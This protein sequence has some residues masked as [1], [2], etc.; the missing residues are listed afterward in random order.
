MNM[1]NGIIINGVEYVLTPYELDD[2]MK[3]DKCAI[4]EMCYNYTCETTF[5][6]GQIINCYF[7]E[8]Q[9]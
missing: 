4:R 5:R 6:Y 8:Y 9:Y 7:E 3:C 2:G 1:E